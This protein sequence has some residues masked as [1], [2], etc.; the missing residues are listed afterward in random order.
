[1]IDE[2]TRQMIFEMRDKGVGTRLIA[3]TLELARST[4]RRILDQGQVTSPTVHRTHDLDPHLE[5]IRRL[6]VRCE[7][8][9]VRVHE[10]L[11]AEA[12]IEYPYSSLTR[13]CRSKRIGLPLEGPDPVGHYV[14]GP[15][16]ES[17]HDTT[18][19]EILVG[20]VTRPYDA[21]ALKHPYSKVR[22]MQFYRR[23]RRFHCKHFLTEGFKFFNGTCGRCV[24]DN[25]SVVIAQGTGIN[26]I[27][28]PEMAAFA[29]RFGFSFLAHEKN[30]SDRKAHVEREIRF[31]QQ[32]FLP[33][34][35]FVDDDDLNRQALEWCRK[36]SAKFNRRLGASP[37]ELLEQER[38]H[39]RQLPAHI[40]DIYELHSMRRVDV[41][42]FVTLNTNQYSVASE[43]IGREVT[44]RETMKEVVILDGPRILCTHP[45]FPEGERAV[46]RLEDHRWGGYR[47]RRES[48][49]RQPEEL[50]VIER[51][52][53]LA[54]YLKGLRHTLGRRYR[55]QARKLYA[56]CHDYAIESVIKAVERAMRYGLYDVDRLERMLL[57]E[58]GVKLF[59]FGDQV[60]EIPDTGRVTPT[61]IATENERDHQKQ[62]SSSVSS[63]DEE[64]SEDDGE[65]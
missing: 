60:R 41:H 57:E 23:F 28:A 2:K 64:E 9:L 6:Y 65:P 49:T 12:G 56:L 50:W 26:A 36:K 7:G 54:L 32:N 63:L 25:T 11:E 14:F 18:K 24:I 53:S 19:V 37:D 8:N 30:H 59:A 27:P 55:Y 38:P 17:Q 42:G 13:Y 58:F 22:F 61:R 15:G 33:G 46:S 51:S 10:E 40:P 16:E 35:T 21:A 1:M 3:K 29:N 34:R 45:R 4:V 48:S 43:F 31:I 44:L 20:K 39:L 52:R 47:A 5:R 62:P